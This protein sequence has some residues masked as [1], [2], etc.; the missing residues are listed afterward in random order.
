M[1][2]ATLG[3]ELAGI[4]GFDRGAAALEKFTAASRKAEM[5]SAGLTAKADAAA[6]RVGQV[7]KA[8]THAA[9]FAQMIDKSSRSLSGF[10]GV[11]ARAG[12]EAAYLAKQMEQVSGRDIRNNDIQEFGREMDQ[13]R[14]KFNPLFA[15]SK[16]YEGELDEINRAHKL[17]AISAM[18][19]GAAIMRLDA[20]YEAAARAANRLSAANRSMAS[21]FHTTNL[22]FQAQDIAMMSMMGQAPLAV[23]LQQGMQVGG[24]FHQI[25]NGRQVVQALGGA[26]TGLL[27]PINLVTIGTIAL[28]AAGVQAFMSWVSSMGPVERSMEDHQKWLGE[29]LKGYDDINKAVNDY[30]DTATRMP[31]TLLR[32]DL[33]EQMTQ[34][35]AQLDS[36]RSGIEEFG[37]SYGSALPFGPFQQ[38]N[39]DIEILRQLRDEYVA[40][41]SDA[42]TFAG[43]LRSI[44]SNNNV[45]PFVRELAQNLY[46]MVRDAADAEAQLGS[47]EIA[48]DRAGQAA[49][50]AAQRTQML[51]ATFAML[52]NGAGQHGGLQNV[53]DEGV[54]ALDSLR[55][56][57]PEIRSTKEIA[58]DLVQTVLDT[59]PT[60]A[61]RQEAEALFNTIIENEAIL[62][63]R[64][65]ANRAAGRQERDPYGDL[66]R[67]A[68]EFIAAQQLE[69]QALGM[70]AEAANRLRYEQDLLNKA[71]NDNIALT[72]AMRNEL[73]G[74]AAQMATTEAQTKMLTQAANDNAALW[75]SVQDG[76]SGI[77]KTWARGGDILDTIKNKLLDIADMLIDMA[78]RNL[79]MGAFGGGGMGG[80][81]GG[82]L[83][84]M[85]IPG[86][87]HSGGVA[88]A[89]GYGHDRAFP[90]ALW[91]GAPRYHN[92]TMGAGLG[93][94]EIPAILERGEI[95][96]PANTNV[97]RQRVHIDVSISVDESG[98]IIP[99]VRQVSGEEAD[100]RVAQS[101]P[102]I[103]G[104]AR[105]GAA[106]DAPGAVAR[107]QKQRGGSDY[108]TM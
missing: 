101:A 88:G 83:G 11:A 64:R 61:A 16:A 26:L 66:T 15:A 71:A 52:G 92:G 108:R 43:S 6:A 12:A 53:M 98:N 100:I 5:A 93:P 70:T 55:R 20:R 46:D 14:A 9:R 103:A 91:D 94:N 96:L 50:L 69:Q 54:A 79:F 35:R 38:F 18:E 47:L 51:N 40:G 24:I 56:M 73:A 4:P 27:S 30:L 72:P 104:A 7:F 65:E 2:V 1:T 3:I 102:V 23:A 48:M 37:L 58:G 36:L 90:S 39:Q 95:V 19:K 41:T 78:V 99:L 86:I 75:G 67:G 8:D 107:Y 49:Q 57:V 87:L 21:S 31:A 34:V 33:G 32:I 60:G 68:M 44:T 106:K 13:L 42:E 105:A 63:A 28:G 89:S 82:L 17:G 84:G 59:L 22:M 77:L 10:E 80:G 25:G 85:I 74:L 62:T 29:I 76:V 81:G 45:S 97:A